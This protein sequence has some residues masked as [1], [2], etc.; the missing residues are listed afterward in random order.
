MKVTTA[1]LFL[2]LAPHAYAGLEVNFTHNTTPTNATHS[3]YGDYIQAT[4]SNFEEVAPGIDARVTGTFVGL[5]HS[6]DGLVPHYAPDNLGLLYTAYDSGGFGSI[7]LKIEFFEGDGVVD[8][9]ALLD[10]SKIIEDL[11]FMVFDIDGDADQDE[12]V[13]VHREDGLV[14]YQTSNLDPLSVSNNGP[15]Y[16]FKG[17][18]TDVA[19]N[20][21]SGAAIFHYRNTDT[22]TVNFIAQT[23]GSAPNEIFQAI[24]GDLS[25]IPLS[26]FSAAVSATPEPSA[27]VL[28]MLAMTGLC[29][30]RRRE[31]TQV[32]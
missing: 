23:S 27:F 19:E 9:V 2:I 26:E 14:S 5:N 24:N 17:A 12:F 4:E 18:G 7:Q 15:M 6:Y 1:A 10:T 8:G 29:R 28:M 3:V 11:S 16:Q 22:V 21:A 25:H 31:T 13:Q 32:S 20:D 30:V